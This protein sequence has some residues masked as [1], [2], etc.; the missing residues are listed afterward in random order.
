MRGKGHCG[1]R[2]SKAAGNDLFIDKYLL[3]NLM[4]GSRV[5]RSLI[6]SGFQSPHSVKPFLSHSPCNSYRLPL[7]GSMHTRILGGAVLS[8]SSGK[9]S[10]Q[11]TYYC[12]VSSHWQNYVIYIDMHISIYTYIAT[13]VSISISKICSIYIQIQ[14]YFRIGNITIKGARLLVFLE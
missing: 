3:N 7:G 1:D 13:S 9:I 14:I 10:V 8:C 5:S 4:P 2:E 12:F 6:T 11:D